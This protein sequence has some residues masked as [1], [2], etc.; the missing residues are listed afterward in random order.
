MAIL[1]G[2]STN[3]I[4]STT[5]ANKPASYPVGQ[6]IFISNAGTKGS[7]WFFDGTRW[8]PMGGRTVLATLDTAPAAIGSTETIVLQYLV[9]AGLWQAGDIIRAQAFVERSGTTDV[10]SAFLRCGTDGTTSD[11]ALLNGASWLS[12]TSK[13]IL[14]LVD[15]RLESATSAQQLSVNFGY[16]SSSL[17]AASPVTITSASANALYVSFSV[18]SAAAT[19]TVTVRSAAI[20]LLSK[21][22]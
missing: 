11:T 3:T 4:L 7:H 19:D 10:T 12:S 8:K 16:G 18:K 1:I 2:G 20:E 21:A 15:F 9:P 13:T 5:W 22:N 14:G 17:G 6:S